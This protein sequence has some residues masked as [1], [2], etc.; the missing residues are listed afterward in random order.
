MNQKNISRLLLTFLL[1]SLL[2]TFIGSGKSAPSIQFSY[3]PT[4]QFVGLTDDQ[5]WVGNSLQLE[6]SFDISDPNLPYFENFTLT[7]NVGTYGDYT[8]IQQIYGR[9]GGANASELPTGYLLQVSDDIQLPTDDIGLYFVF[10][11]SMWSWKG[12]DDVVGSF[13]DREATSTVSTIWTGHTPVSTI[14]PT[15]TTGIFVIIFAIVGIIL[16]YYLLSKSKYNR[17]CDPK[18]DYL[19]N[20]QNPN[21]DPTNQVC[22][23]K[24]IK[25]YESQQQQPIDATKLPP[26]VQAQLALYKLKQQE[27]QEPLINPLPI[28]TPTI[29]PIQNQPEI[30]KPEQ[31]PQKEV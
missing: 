2:T 23:S 6:W 4:V 17:F 13:G 27:A 26:N 29:Q 25:G 11:I 15:V 16:I 12:G 28:I 24:G 22:K 7:M 20:P 5:E 3:P 8:L 14:S 18:P 19:G 21:F 30:S 31:Q 1:T 9:Y 10:T